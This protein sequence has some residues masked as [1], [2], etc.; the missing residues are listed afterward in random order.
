MQIEILRNLTT[1][2]TEL[3]VGE[4]MGRMVWLI[5][6]SSLLSVIYLYTGNA[7]SNKKRLAAIFPLMSL[8]TM[9]IISIIKVSLTLSL[10]LVGALSIV[11]F[12]AAIKDPEEL[13]YIFLAITL[14]L[15]FGAGQIGLTSVSFG[16]ILVV[17]AIQ[18]WLRGRFNRVWLEKDSVQLELVFKKKQGLATV[19]KILDEH[20]V[21]IKLQRMSEEKEQVMV[22]LIKPKSVESLEM[23]R[24][25]SKK[26]DENLRLRMSQYRPLV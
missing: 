4:L 26:L 3:R 18:A 11:R 6:L 16:V 20:C 24:R 9:L 2:L 7:L 12:R 14:G 8:T 1:V 25:E 21:E 22:F 5:L 17:I 15:G 13:V 23:I 19:T 10:G